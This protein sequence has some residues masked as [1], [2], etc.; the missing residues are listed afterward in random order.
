MI[1]RWILHLLLEFKIPLLLILIAGIIYPIAY[2]MR[3]WGRNTVAKTAPFGCKV[4]RNVETLLLSLM[5]LVVFIYLLTNVRAGGLL[6][7]LNELRPAFVNVYLTL[8]GVVLLILAAAVALAFLRRTTWAVVIVAAVLYIYAFII[9]GP[10]DLL[11]RLVNL[12]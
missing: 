8:A 9:D 6:P 12:F 10:F 7:R 3:L 1:F 2:R 5:T 11:R 4:S